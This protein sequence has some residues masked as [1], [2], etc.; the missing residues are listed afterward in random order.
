MDRNSLRQT[1]HIVP[2]G[3][4]FD[5]AITPF[6]NRNV[7]R[8]ILV[9]DTGNRGRDGDSEKEK[10]QEK[11]TKKVENHL[12]SM[13]I[14]V[15]IE[16]ADTFNL[17]ELIKKFSSLIKKEKESNNAVSINM[18]SSGRLVSVAAAIAG[19]AHDIAVYYVHSK[20]YSS[21]KDDFENHGVTIC[22][23]SDPNVTVLNNFQIKI[24]SEEY[25]MILELMYVR[26]HELNEPWTSPN[27]IGKML[28]AFFKEKYPWDPDISTKKS[29]RPNK[30][31][32]K[33]KSVEYRKAQSQ[34]LIKFQK[35]LAK[36][37]EDD[38]Y[39]IRKSGERKHV[40]YQITASGEYAL[41]LYGITGKI[42]SNDSGEICYNT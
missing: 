12:K 3:F 14:A 35:S 5:R 19:M 22:D 9:V 17:N 28:H 6:K 21:N 31:D 25:G 24:P 37:L 23:L 29:G 26:K 32:K 4:E 15:D 33:T 18:S 16:K 30:A 8:V 7:D 13:G 40:Y 41:F 39:I 2:L 27:E 36:D 1:V 20:D 10:R 38:K 11:Y 34:F 42:S